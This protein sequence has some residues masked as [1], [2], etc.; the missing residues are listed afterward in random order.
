MSRKIRLIGILLLGFYS[1]CFAQ[2]TERNNSHFIEP[3]YMIGKIVPLSKK[4]V[5]PPMGYQKAVAINYGFTNNDTTKWGKYYNYAESGFMLQYS[6]LGNNKIFGHQL[7]L[8]PFVSFRVFNNFKHPFKVKL[9]AGVAYFTTRF[10]SLS[11][12]QNELI[13]S[14]FTWDVK[15]FLY[16]SIYKRGGFQLKLGAGF[17]HESNGHT[18]LPNLGIN[19]TMAS[20]SGQFYN[21][22]EDNHFKPKRVKRQN[23]S[24]KNY[25]ITLEEGIGFHEQDDTEGPKMGVLKPVYSS[26]L[27]AAVLFNKHIKLRAGFTYRLYKQYYDHVVE[28]QIEKLIDNPTWSASNVSFYLGNEFLMGHMSIDV[29][30]GVNLHK[31]FFRQFNQGTELGITLQKTLLTRVGLNLYLIN[32][33]KLPVH[34]LFIGAH[35]KANMAKADYTDITLG[36]TYRFN[37]NR[38]THHYVY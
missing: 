37:A 25:Y 30:L 28:N 6:N 29:L 23:V 5:F 16:K 13:G 14:A 2:K 24:P 9:G 19:S 33:H 12:P 38:K 27:S 32:T 20:I 17:S 4:F 26:D 10:D 7:S 8:L 1:L 36:Y 11:N 15:V 35:I 3:E 21:Q 18:R 34:N 31:P 22:K